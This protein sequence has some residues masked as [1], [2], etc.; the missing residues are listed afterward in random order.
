MT[1]YVTITEFSDND[2]ATIS[3][4]SIEE[5]N[6][7]YEALNHIIKRVIAKVRITDDEKTGKTTAE[8]FE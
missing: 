8:L 7:W 3:F 2:V 5:M 6:E 4:E 1:Y